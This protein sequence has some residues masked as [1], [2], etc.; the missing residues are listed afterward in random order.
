L[1]TFEWARLLALA[2][3]IDDLAPALLAM[4]VRVINLLPRVKV[5]CYHRDQRGSWSINAAL[6]TVAPY[7]DYGDLA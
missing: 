5:N 6:P 7:P 1:A 2:K 4:E 3:T